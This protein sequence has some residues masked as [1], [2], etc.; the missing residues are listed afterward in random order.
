MALLVVTVFVAFF[1]V[2]A[3]AYVARALWRINKMMQA[4]PLPVQIGKKVL[5]FLLSRRQW[6]TLMLG[7]IAIAV[8]TGAVAGVDVM[9]WNAR[10]APGAASGNSP[11]PTLSPSPSPSPSPSVLPSPSDSVSPSDPYSSSGY[12]DPSYSYQ[13]SGAITYLD[14]VDPVG[15]TISSHGAVSFGGKRY[16][17]SIQ[18]YCYRPTQTY[19]EWNVAGSSKFTATLGISDDTEDSFGAIAEM[20][21]YDQDGHEL[22]PKPVDVSVGH[23]QP[24]EIPLSG[25]VHL[26]VT[27]SGRDAK[28]NDVRSTTAAF[29][30]ALIVAA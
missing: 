26:R 2:L 7:L 16:P 28:T 21:F 23:P 19:L 20:I 12:P 25:V 30:D 4:D 27:C 3:T 18:K 22:L 24:V 6:Y 5:W 13:N 15:G 10:S 17:R 14:N 8:S 11:S 1:L 9:R 29:G